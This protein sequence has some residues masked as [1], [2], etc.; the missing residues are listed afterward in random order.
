MK[1]LS[2]FLISLSFTGMLYSA[3]LDTFYSSEVI[4]STSPATTPNINSKNVKVKQIII[5][6]GSVAQN[7]TF[8]KNALST[9]TVVT[10]ISVKVPA[11]TTL[12]LQSNLVDDN[13]YFNLPYFAVRTSTDTTKANILVIYKDNA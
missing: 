6:N 3:N 10:S 13:Y 7:L 12:Y 4:Y 1:N 2:L 9:T 5:T 11:S 8:Y